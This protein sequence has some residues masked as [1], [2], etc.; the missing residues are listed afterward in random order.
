[1]SAALGVRC[2]VRL[3]DRLFTVPDPDAE[4]GDF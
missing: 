4:E 3:Y 1:V 2:E